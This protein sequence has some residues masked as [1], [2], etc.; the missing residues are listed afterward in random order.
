LQSKGRSGFLEQLFSN[1]F[2]VQLLHHFENKNFDY[3]VQELRQFFFNYTNTAL[4]VSRRWENGKNLA[5]R[6]KILLVQLYTDD[7]IDSDEIHCEMKLAGLIERM[8]K[9]WTSFYLDD[10]ENTVLNEQTIKTM[11]DN[12]QYLINLDHVKLYLEEN[13]SDQNF[14]NT[15]EFILNQLYLQNDSTTETKEEINKIRMLVD[16][17]IPEVMIYRRQQVNEWMIEKFKQEFR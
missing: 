8:K 1:T 15:C 7:F 3:E 10:E 17:L 4:K 11:F 13:A 16:E 12:K 5:D 6:L 9:A 14:D 2:K